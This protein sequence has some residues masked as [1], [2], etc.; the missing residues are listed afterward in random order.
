MKSFTASTHLGNVR[1]RLPDDGPPEVRQDGRTLAVGVP[2]SDVEDGRS[3]LVFSYGEFGD[4]GLICE[5]LGR[6]EVRQV[7]SATRTDADGATVS[8]SDTTATHSLGVFTI[9]DFGTLWGAR[10]G[11]KEASARGFRFEDGE[12]TLETWAIDLVP[13]KRRCCGR[14]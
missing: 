9:A 13:V 4:G 3:A 8:V 11:A 12:Q 2:T 6:P 7:R 14:S 5:P 10:L 1:V